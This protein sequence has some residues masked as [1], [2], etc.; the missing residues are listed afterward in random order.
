VATVEELLRATDELLSDGVRRGVLHHVAEDERLDGRTVTV[1]G[2]RLVN[3]G[4]CS[5][6]GLE[7][8]PAMTAAVTDAVERFG[9]QFSSSRAYLSSPAYH[10]AE[11]VLAELFGRPVM[12]SSSTS[13]GHLAALPTLIGAGDALILDH[14]VHHS[15]QVAATVVRAHGATVTLIPHNDMSTLERRVTELARTHRRIWYA[16]DGLYSMYADYAPIDALNA[17]A[18]RHEQL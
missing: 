3:F 8:H 17:L 2:R 4:S 13:L 5:Y 12:I 10:E 18:E 9:T 16:A 14:Q 6:L 1:R 11:A 7:L 15:V